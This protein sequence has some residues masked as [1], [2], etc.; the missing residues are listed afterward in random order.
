MILLFVPF[1]RL[2][3]SH[4]SGFSAISCTCTR[5]SYICTVHVFMLTMMI[6]TFLIS[7]K[8]LLFYFILFNH[9]YAPLY[10]DRMMCAGESVLL[11]CGIR[12]IK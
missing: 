12:N 9:H 2:C 8:L 7:F 5:L 11:L 6:E 4:S 10:Q 1:I 3:V